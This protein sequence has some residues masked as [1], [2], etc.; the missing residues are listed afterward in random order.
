MVK[1]E[2]NRIVSW[3]IPAGG[4]ELFE[5]L[6]EAV[7]REVEEEAGILINTPR[8][9]RIFNFIESNKTTTNFLYYKV[10]TKLKQSNKEKNKNDDELILE[11][12]FFSL[13]EIFEILENRKYE[14]KIAETRLKVF[15]DLNFKKNLNPYSI[16]DE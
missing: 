4:I 6:D 12:K 1:E 16:K 2:Q 5:S 15:T 11:T 9:I 13:N 3:D 10:L 8:L 14:H 7:V